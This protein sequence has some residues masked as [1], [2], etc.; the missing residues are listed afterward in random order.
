[1]ILLCISLLSVFILS[2]FGSVFLRLSLSVINFIAS[3]GISFI[4]FGI[5]PDGMNFFAAFCSVFLKNLSLPWT[6]SSHGLLEKM[7]SVIMLDGSTHHHY[8]LQ[9]KKPRSNE[10][11]FPQSLRKEKNVPTT[12]QDSTSSQVTSIFSILENLHG[13]PIAYL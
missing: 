9:R 5:L 3:V 7:F 6:L 13:F 12:L 4:T 2:L 8:L 10:K 1:M 11:S